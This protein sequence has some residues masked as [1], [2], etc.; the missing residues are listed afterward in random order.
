MINDYSIL[1]EAFLEQLVKPENN[2]LNNKKRNKQ[3]NDSKKLENSDI[4]DVEVIEEYKLI[5]YKNNINE[6]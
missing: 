6:K 3:L 4:I 1:L 5:E 2:N